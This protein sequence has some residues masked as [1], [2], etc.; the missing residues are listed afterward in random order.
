MLQVTAGSL[1]GIFGS[2]VKAVAEQFMNTNIVHII[3]TDAHDLTRRTL[4]LRK[5]YEYVSK[6]WGS[7]KA[8]L[9]CSINPGK[10]IKG[11]TIDIG[12]PFEFIDESLHHQPSSMLDRV[13]SIFRQK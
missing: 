10:V 12:E 2:Q 9:L 5:A 13:R 11:E 1:L 3:A 7:E 4:K 8:D 6:K